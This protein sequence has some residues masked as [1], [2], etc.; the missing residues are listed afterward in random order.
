MMIW[1]PF[2]FL[3]TQVDPAIEHRYSETV[4]ETSFDQACDTNYDKW[5][6][7]WTRRKGTGFPEYVNIRIDDSESAESRCLR[8]ELDGG[9]AI[10]Y[11]PPI[12]IDSLFNYV[13]R[14]QIKTEGL[15]HNVAY[16]SLSFLDREQRKKETYT[17][18]KL[19]TASE[20]RDLVIGP[21]IPEDPDVE[22]AV[23]GLHLVP[24]M[25]SD[26]T[27]A[28]MFDNIRL[29][30]LPDMT[31]ETDQAGNLY[32]E[33]GPARITC[34]VS[35]MPRPD[36]PVRFELVGVNGQTLAR[37]ELKLSKYSQF[38]GFSALDARLSSDHTLL[39][40]DHTLPFHDHSGYVGR[41]TWCPR[42]PGHGFFTVRASL[43]NDDKATLQRTAPLVVLE[44]PDKQRKGEFGWSIPRHD[45]ELSDDALVSLLQAANASWV[46]YP[47][48]YDPRDAEGE[49][50]RLADLADRFSDTDIEMVGVLDTPSEQARKALWKKE[51][52]TAAE[53]VLEADMWRSTIDKLLA[54]FS[55]KIQWW[56]LGADGNESFVDYHGLTPKLSRLRSHLRRFGQR[57]RLGVAWQWMHDVPECSAPPW[58]FL[59][60]TE[61]P[62]FT[63]EELS[64]H[65]TH[66]E[67]ENV[68]HWVTLRPL[69]RDTY[70]THS[71]A[72]D[73]I[74]R[75]ITAKVNGVDAI[76]AGDV[77]NP[78]HGLVNT[79]GTPN[80]LFPPWCIASRMLSGAEYMGS[81]QLPH[82]SPNHVF[83]R[84]G[85]AILA[86]WNQD[87]VTESIYL[88]EDVVQIDP[89]GRQTALANA[90]E[91]SSNQSQDVAVGPLPTFVKGLNLAVARWRLNVTFDPDRLDSKFGHVQS[92]NYRFKNTFDQSVRGTMKLQVPDVWDARNSYLRFKLGNDKE[93]Q[94]DFD[95][96][97]QTN[98]SS[99]PQPVSLVF[100]VFADREYE[101]KVHRTIHVGMA[102][103]AAKL[104]TWLDRDGK[105]IVKQHLINQ[106]DQRLDF[107]CYLF[108]PGR[109][110]MR[111]QVFDIGPGQVTQ[112]YTLRNGK[113][114][115]G[116]SLWLRVEE[117][118]GKRLYNYH[119]EVQP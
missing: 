18:E 55:L 49:S 29:A 22:L 74:L 50:Q 70:D 12:E 94:R 41:V 24:T 2:L 77:L 33:P 100:N 102:D 53:A 23:I 13:F 64:T 57:V 106:T 107:N 91:S 117:L 51:R 86:V 73:L 38:D 8:V 112:T 10:A 3:P 4:F 96:L 99:G 92:S 114:L 67:M 83:A 47:I 79:D 1:L 66:S 119:V 5:P 14:G 109:R 62:P 115:L 28:A 11:S 26:L 44:N 103:L 37:D 118:K 89:W 81:L 104:D 60:M 25:Q 30:R 32:H 93:L 82:G 40:S 98:A 76:F 71:R 52:L 59:A 113:E 105:L 7:N 39:S 72:R 97:L 88:G 19:T 68:P 45:S 63:H 110:R 101:F 58:D 20:W 75:M 65:A 80:E 6:D 90:G 95:V 69:P 54:K 78:S 56:Q 84:D 27:G 116:E 87:A 15:T 21:L 34:T 111:M 35:G 43:G 48:W 31:L 46:K 16:F 42:L 61:S 17:S 36:A 108:I 85:K 9:G